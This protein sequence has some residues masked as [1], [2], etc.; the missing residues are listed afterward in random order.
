V[1]ILGEMPFTVTD[2]LVEASSDPSMVGS[3]ITIR[4]TGRVDFLVEGLTDRLVEGKEYLLM[5]YVFR[6]EPDGPQIGNQY[7][8]SGERAAWEFTS[9]ET[10]VAIFPDDSEGIPLELGPDQAAQVLTV[11]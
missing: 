9:G 6:M 8:I 2:F 10:A 7:C 3:T 11:S 1:E 5:V 4:Q